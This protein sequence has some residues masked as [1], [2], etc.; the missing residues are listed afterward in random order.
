MKKIEVRNI[1]LISVFKLFGGMSF[2][3]G[4]IIVLFGGGFGDAQFQQQMQNIPFIGSMLKGFFGSLIMGVVIAVI[5]GLGAMLNAALYNI[6]AMIV[7]GV[8]I[9][10]KD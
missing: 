7:G 10:I 3:I 6:F 4:F 1:D 2:V 9:E 8:E 5:C